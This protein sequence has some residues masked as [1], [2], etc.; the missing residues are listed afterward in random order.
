MRQSSA[1][2]DQVTDNSRGKA[3]SHI[4]ESAQATHILIRIV[5][6]S[7]REC[8]PAC[9]RVCHD[10][11]ISQLALPWRCEQRP[12]IVCRS[13]TT[14]GLS[15]P[16][17]A[18]RTAPAYCRNLNAPTQCQAEEAPKNKCNR[19]LRRCGGPVEARP[20]IE[21]ESKKKLTESN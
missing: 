17:D 13:V 4:S 18:V 2:N 6:C 3:A 7:G 9:L 14:G 12:P 19:I 11:G 15:V 1:F 20:L 10:G 21:S 5:S 16:A 8:G